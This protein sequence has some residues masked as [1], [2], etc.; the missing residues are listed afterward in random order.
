MT[1]P[2]ICVIFNPAAG[3]SRA[4]QRIET[5]RQSWGDRVAFRPTSHPRH[6]IELARQASLDGFPI[7]AG[8]GGDGTIHEVANGILQS[9]REDVRFAVFP[10]GSANDFAYSL[11]H[12]KDCPS[13]RWIDVGKVTADDGRS[14]HFV[15]CTGLGFSGAVTVEAQRIRKLQGMLLYGWATM[16]ALWRRYEVPMMEL[17]ID[18][19]T[20][21][22]PTLMFSL[23]QGKREGGFV[24][25]PN[26]LLDD[27]WFD[28][29]QVGRMSRFEVMRFLPRLALFGPT[30]NHPKI[31]QG[32]CRSVKIRSEAPM[33]VHLDGELLCTQEDGLRSFE[34][35]LKPRALC[36]D[37]E[38]SR[39]APR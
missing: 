31:R 35:E 11:F 24:L 14:A 2:E 23:L 12:E 7:V 30:A 13:Q 18:G 1:R 29:F 15:C 16:K 37:V 36:V 34:M 19:E 25:A 21:R 39:Q 6:G 28:Y 33:N 10:I 5:L 27:G 32:R 8:A 26:A 22:T 20:T 4:S 9:G 38:V 17:E 3:K